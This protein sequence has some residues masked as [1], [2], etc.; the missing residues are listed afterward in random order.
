MF[1]SFFFNSLPTKQ[2]VNVSGN[3]STNLREN[4]TRT[5]N[6]SPNILGCT[7]IVIVS[8]SSDITYVPGGSGNKNCNPAT[9]TVTLQVQDIDTGAVTSLGSVNRSNNGTFISNYTYT[10]SSRSNLRLVVFSS[11]TCGTVPNQTWN[12][13]T[14]VTF[15]FL[16]QESVPPTNTV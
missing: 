7:Q 13:N 11:S 3:S 9:Q 10:P 4:E 1:N 15:N 8:A 6:L 2:S 5:I 14:N 16:F 12:F